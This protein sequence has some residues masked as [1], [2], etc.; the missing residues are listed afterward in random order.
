[1]IE[2]WYTNKSPGSQKGNQYIDIILF[3]SK[4]IADGRDE[5]NYHA[6]AM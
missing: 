6:M 3:K 1:M 5:P 4:D 2:K